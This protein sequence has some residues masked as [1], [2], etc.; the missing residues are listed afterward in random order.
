MTSFTSQIAAIRVQPDKKVKQ[1]RYVPR[2]P[3][4]LNLFN[5]S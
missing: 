5:L 4:I 3:P 1:N 2:Y